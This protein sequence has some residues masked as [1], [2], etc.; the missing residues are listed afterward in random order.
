MNILYIDDDHEHASTLSAYLCEQEPEFHFDTVSTA[1]EAVERLNLYASA[2]GHAKVAVPWPRNWEKPPRYD[3]VLSVISPA[4]GIGLEVL[5]HAS[6]LDLPLPVVILIEPDEHK[7]TL[8][9]LR[10]GATDYLVKSGNYLSR[11][12]AFALE[13]VHNFQNQHTLRITPARVVLGAAQSEDNDLVRH[14]L[15]SRT[16][17]LEILTFTNAD[18]LLDYLG[19]EGRTTSRNLLLLDHDL[20]G[21]DTIELLKEIRH[22]RH[23]DLPII[24]LAQVFPDD[25]SLSAYQ[26]GVRDFLVKSPANLQR[27]P[28]SIENA[29]WQAQAQRQ[30][31]ALRQEHGH[32]QAIIDSTLDPIITTDEKQHV[33]LF[34]KAAEKMFGCSAETAI[35]TSLERFIPARFRSAHREHLVTL[36]HASAPPVSLSGKRSNQE[37]FPMEIAASVVRVDGRRFYTFILRDIT[38][39]MQSDLLLQASSDFIKDVLNSLLSGVV[40]I[41]DQ[42]IIIALNAVWEKFIAAY[43]QSPAIH[44]G[45][46]AD[47]F[48]L[49]PVLLHAGD[50][51]K[52]ASVINDIRQVIH[53]TLQ[54]SEHEFR[55]LTSQGERWFALRISPLTGTCQGAVL[56]HRD[57]TQNKNLEA[58]LRQSQ[59]M[60]ALG[61]LSGGVAH[62]FNNILTV[63]Q[64]QTASLA[65]S[66]PL[67]P[68]QKENFDEIQTTIDRAASLT[69]QLLA[70]GRRQTMCPGNL[71]LNQI[72]SSSTSMLR[73]IIGEDIELQLHPSAQKLAVHA[74]AGMI[75]QVL[76]N[77]VVNSREAMP[78]GGRLIIRT[79]CVTLSAAEALKN[80]QSRPGT[81]I[82]L[83]VRDTGTGIPAAIVHRI[84][85]PF[86]TTKE[87]GKG[88]GLGLA[89]VYGIVQQHHGWI[90]VDSL[91]NHGSTFT[92]H[93]PQTSATAVD[94]PGT[95]PA[96]ATAV[97]GRETILIAE[98][99]P[100]LRLIVRAALGGLGYRILE[101]STGREA[102]QLWKEHRDEI[103][104]LLTDMVMPD[105]M[106]GKQLGEKIHATAPHLPIIYMS[107]YHFEQAGPDFPLHEGHNY[108]GKPFH[109]TKLATTLRARLDEAPAK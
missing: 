57:I 106:S 95:F 59:K 102:L 17:H 47:Y 33:I 70:F 45:I 56:L 31:L 60:E 92:I 14:I 72:V 6:R 103:R 81:F 64:L 100:N 66:G 38:R 16:P 87:A 5:A 83:Q 18:E 40:V 94:L 41:N 63:I 1:Y 15:Q 2:Y 54:N 65:F 76:L 4:A 26:L 104:L 88:T 10:A 108:L 71:D 98:D 30:S 55:A 69:R 35:G 11:L 22:V 12:P 53:G 78:D 21:L 80:P 68:G 109:P 24:L 67:T 77:L 3:L 9:A 91:P 97:G 61:Q 19:E 79:G 44:A 101:A 107:G 39:K 48:Q 36:T 50:E 86:F 75:E 96:L 93:L 58:Q 62:D 23:L 34:N 51:E 42:G 46:G 52:G 8:Q 85:D 29:W 13:A 20:P 73:R 7:E 90:Q 82:T 27:L 32:F 89:T 25:L 74:D 99:E 105:G 49:F 28:Y 43:S 37:E 84:F